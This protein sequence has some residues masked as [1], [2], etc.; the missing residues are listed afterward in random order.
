MLFSINSFVEHKKTKGIYK[1]LHYA[2]IEK[3]L[4]SVVVYQSMSDGVIW[5]RP[6]GEFCDG[7]FVKEE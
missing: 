3:T 1:V 7:R 6:V 2:K 5:V 4:E